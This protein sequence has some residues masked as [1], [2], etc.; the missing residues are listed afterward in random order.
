[1]AR[2]VKALTVVIVSLAMQTMAAAVVVARPPMVPMRYWLPCRAE[3][4]V[5]ACTLRGQNSWVLERVDILLE[6]VAAAFVQQA[7]L[8]L[9]VMEA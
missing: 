6:A 4:V 1:M 9:W 8:V 3:T 7:V 5:M 2:R